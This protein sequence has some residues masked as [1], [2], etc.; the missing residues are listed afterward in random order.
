MGLSVDEVRA[1]VR[2]AVEAL[3]SESP[4]AASEDQKALLRLLA[5]REEGY[6]DIGALMGLS[7]AEVRSRVRDALG[8]LGGA[9]EPTRAPVKEEAAKAEAAAAAPKAPAPEPEPP[10]PR[11]A[12]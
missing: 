2:T 10:A 12:P 11:T 4:E 7:V 6:E 1:R 5:Q 9:A 3:Q 8:E